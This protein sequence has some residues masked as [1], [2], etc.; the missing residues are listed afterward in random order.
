MSRD[1]TEMAERVPPPFRQSLIEL[2]QLGQ[3][4]AP[5]GDFHVSLHLQFTGGSVEFSTN[6][7]GWVSLEY[8]A[9]TSELH[10]DQLDGHAEIAEFVELLQAVELLRRSEDG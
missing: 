6:H 1:L 2:L 4:S 3:M 8:S 10:Y 7:L 5:D 9:L